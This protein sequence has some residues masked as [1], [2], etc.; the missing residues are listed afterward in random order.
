MSHLN[1]F[2]SLTRREKKIFCEA[3]F[4]LL[5]C[6]LIVKTIPFKHIYRRLAA[7]SNRYTQDRL[8][9]ADDI[10]AVNLSLSR[11]AK[12]LPWEGLCLSRS[13]AA[14]IML[15]RRDIAAV[16]FAGAKFEGSSL[17]LAHAWVRV[18]SGVI[19]KSPKDTTFTTLI[20]IGN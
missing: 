15:R 11:A 19:E 6:Q 16:V 5:L 14:L 7:S 9:V 17:L 10:R 3:A 12:L 18:G 20:R 1:K 8:G 2:W 13:I 4:L